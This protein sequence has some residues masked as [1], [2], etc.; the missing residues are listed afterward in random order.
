[1]MGAFLLD[2]VEAHYQ[3]AACRPGEALLHVREVLAA[4][5]AA[6]SSLISNI[7]E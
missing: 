1:M 3:G 7:N 2:L 6:S 5:L 4:A